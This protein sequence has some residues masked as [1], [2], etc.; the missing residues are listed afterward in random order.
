MEQEPG[1]RDATHG[2]SNYQVLRSPGDRPGP[3]PLR[4]TSAPPNEPE[5]RSAGSFGVLSFQ[6]SKSCDATE[7]LHYDPRAS[8]LVCKEH[9]YALTSWKWHLSNYHAFNR[10]ELKDA[11]RKLR[12]LDVV[13]PEDAP[14]PTANEPALPF[15]LPSRKGYQCWGT[16]GDTCGYIST[17]CSK[18]AEHCNTAHG[19]RSSPRDRNH[20]SEVKVQTFC[21]IPGKQRWFIVR[22]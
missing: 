15:L 13:R 6:S 18:I 8:V 21:T 5:T 20:W 4:T 9:G 7:C 12:G 11:A 3:E 17:S 19:W 2:I 22:D 10:D 1:E 14:L 16:S